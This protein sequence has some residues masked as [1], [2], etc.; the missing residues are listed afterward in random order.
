MLGGGLAGLGVMGL[1]GTLSGCKGGGSEAVPETPYENGLFFK[2]SLAQWSLHK[3]YFGKSL[4]KGFG[5]FIEALHKDPKSVLQG[6][7]NPGVFPKMAKQLFEIDAVEF[8]NTFY[9]DL[10]EDTYYMTHLGEQCSNEGVTPLLIMCD[11]LGDLGDLDD[12]KRAA[13]VENHYKWIN[14]AKLIGC[15]SIR[16]NAAGSGTAEEVKSAAVDGLGRL[17][18][19]GESNEINVIVE[20]HGGYSSNGEWLAS[21][22]E[23]VDN[24][25][26]GTL[27]DFG[28][29]CI[30]RSD[31]FA[32]IEEYDR[33][34]GVKELMPYAKGVSAKTNE[35]DTWG[36]ELNTDYK[37]MLQIVKDAGYRGYIGIEYEGDQHHETTGIRISK[38]LLERIGAEIT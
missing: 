16:V 2:I 1:A 11:A 9:F 25:Y 29:F 4:D 8:V 33:Y 32:C 26:C 38:H 5:P 19:Y 3:S 7:Q 15:H 14:A 30:K 23:Q 28:N 17:S 24:P 10:A 13:A 18:E 12:Q 22:I 21:V 36:N 34:Q 6:G 27:P 31:D 20:N 35:F 37:K